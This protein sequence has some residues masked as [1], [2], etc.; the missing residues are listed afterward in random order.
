MKPIQVSKLQVQDFFQWENVAEQR[1][2]LPKFRSVRAV[3]F[4]KGDHRLHYKLRLDSEKFF[5]KPFRKLQPLPEFPV[6]KTELRGINEK[7]KREICDNL[8]SL[9]PE[10]H[11]EFWRN[12]PAKAVAD[13]GKT[14]D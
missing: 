6:S 5:A 13:L 4:V 7:K 12:L 8:I 14:Q 3:R 1:A 2:T 11:R 9:I 10:D